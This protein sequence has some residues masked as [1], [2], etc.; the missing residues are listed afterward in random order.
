AETQR[1]A[2]ELHAFIKYMTIYKP[3]MEA[4]ESDAPSMPINDTL[5]GA[6]SN[7]ATVIQC[8]FKAGIPVW[9][10]VVMKDLP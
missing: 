4:P 3:L 5:V 2:C 10:I 8:F 1:I 7:D 6:F 9:H